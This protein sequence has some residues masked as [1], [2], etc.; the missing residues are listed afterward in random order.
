MEQTAEEAAGRMRRDPA[1]EAAERVRRDSAL[2]R[3][4]DH[5]GFVE[6]VAQKRDRNPHYYPRTVWNP[7]LFFSASGQVTTIDPRGP[8]SQTNPVDGQPV[9]GRIPRG[10]SSQINPVGGQ[11]VP[12]RKDDGELDS[13]LHQSI[14]QPQMSRPQN[15]SPTRGRITLPSTPRNTGSS[16]TRGQ[17]GGRPPG[18]QTSLITIG[19]KGPSASSHRQQLGQPSSTGPVAQSPYFASRNPSPERP[20]LRQSHAIAQPLPGP[21]RLNRTP[22]PLPYPSGH[23]TS[24]QRQ[25]AGMASETDVSYLGQ[26]AILHES[27]MGRRRARR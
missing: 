1:E 23:E 10:P 20:P 22:A 7:Q 13:V 21:S 14:P 9:P 11:P 15:I 17:V 8:S 26:L 24:P 25:N 4:R 16:S 2:R 27:S 19:L 5:G 3:I 18:N 12:G 6:D